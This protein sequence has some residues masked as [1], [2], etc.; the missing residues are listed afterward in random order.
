[1]AVVKNRF[2]SGGLRQP[3]SQELQDALLSHHGDEAW[4][5][6]FAESLNLEYQR[7]RDALLNSFVRD[8]KQAFD[9]S[10]NAVLPQSDLDRIQLGSPF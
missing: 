4:M 1:M 2:G 5:V 10:P 6:A 9:A 8:A 7:R 3:L